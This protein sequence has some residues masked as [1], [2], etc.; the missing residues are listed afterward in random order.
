MA[1][2]VILQPRVGDMDALRTSPALPL[3]PLHAVSLAAPEFDTRLIDQRLDPDWRA[4]LKD[5]I[6]PETL[7]VCFTAFTGPMILSNIEMAQEARKHT[8]APMVWGGIHSTL[9]SEI[10]LKDDRVDVIIRGEGEQTLLELARALKDKRPLDDLEGL[11]HKKDG[12]IVRNPDR[13]MLDLDDM[14]EIPYHLVDVE[15]YMPRYMGRKSLYFQSSRGCRHA[16]TYCFNTRFNKQHFRSQSAEKTLERVQ[17][18]VDKYGAED[19]YFVDDNFFVDIERDRAILHGMKEIGVTWQIQGVDIIA[20]KHMDGD[21][22]KLM[23][24]SGLK[25]LTVGIESGSPRIRKLMKKAGTVQDIETTI[26]RLAERDMLVFCSFLTGVPTETE[27]ELKET[28]N[29]L[30]KLLE[31]NPK[32]RNSPIY[33]YTPYPGTK[34]YELAVE[35]G[36]NPPESLEEWG[37]V[38]SW[39]VFSWQNRTDRSMHEAL[40]FV[41]NFL[42]C[43]TREY[44]VPLAIK[45][46]GDL[47][48]PL[49]RW[50]VKNLNF[51]FLIEKRLADFAQKRLEKQISKTS[52]QH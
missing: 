1:E 35:H 48:R 23:E 10:T 32:L 18:L 25:R 37:K 27:A 26:A 46:A 38:G 5:A 17:Y 33:N 24:E 34:M 3:G 42:D 9:E 43:K 45:L 8:A 4:A 21:F 19:I 36:Y 13:A 47:Y 22:M 29:L 11:W 12:E 14:P 6:G 52:L 40:Y 39:D 31:I 44:D 28:I 15:R 30:L 16:C 50:R 20:L 2:L 51:S 7:A 41:S 49:A